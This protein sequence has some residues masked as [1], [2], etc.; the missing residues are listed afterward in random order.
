M[1]LLV[2]YYSLIARTD[3]K[4]PFG[5][6]GGSSEIR[7]SPVAFHPVVSIQSPWI[8]GSMVG[9]DDGNTIHSENTEVKGLGQGISSE[10]ARHSAPLMCESGAPAGAQKS[11][12]RLGIFHRSR[13][14]QVIFPRKIRQEEAPFRP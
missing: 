7:G 12:W 11:H 10:M 1:T 6:L 8:P 14:I 3:P 13:S 2:L 5:N 9:L 4:K